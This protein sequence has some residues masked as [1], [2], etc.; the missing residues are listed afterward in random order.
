MLSYLNFENL[1]I[2]LEIFIHCIIHLMILI[3]FHQCKLLVWFLSPNYQSF[4]VTYL[5][6]LYYAYASN[7]L[8]LILIYSIFSLLQRQ[9]NYYTICS[10]YICIFFI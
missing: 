3:I 10:L 6:I 1:L 9:L 4:I 7:K 5:S 2:F 8:K